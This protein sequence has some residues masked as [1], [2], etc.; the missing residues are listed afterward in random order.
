MKNLC[1][2]KIFFSHL[3]IFKVVNSKTDEIVKFAYMMENLMKFAYL[4]ENL[5]KFAYL[6]E[7]FLCLLQFSNSIICERYI[8]IRPL[9]EKIVHF[10]DFFLSYLCFSYSFIKFSQ[11]HKIEA[12]IEPALISSR[13]SYVDL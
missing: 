13:L 12:A 5:V 11:L 6:M 10:S 2:K 8:V 3:N 7:N 9:L 4:M 1:K